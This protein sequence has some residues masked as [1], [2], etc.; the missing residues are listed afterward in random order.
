[1]KTKKHFFLAL[2][3]LSLSLTL[4]SLTCKKKLSPNPIENLPPAT[5]EGKNTFGCLV[6]GELLIPRGNGFNV[7]LTA[8]KTNNNFYI[9]AS[10]SYSVKRIIVLRIEADNITNSV[11]KCIEIYQDAST[12]R[13][14]QPVNL[15]LTLSKL[16]EVNKI[17]SG[18]FSAILPANSDLPEFKVTD[19]RFDLKYK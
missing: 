2:T 1:M 5:Q 9:S 15:T 6:N 14:C 7:I 11:L 3:L 18:K 17:I 13:Y 4:F 19:G 10:D 16:D 12:S 8:E